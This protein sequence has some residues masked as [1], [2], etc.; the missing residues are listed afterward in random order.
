MGKHLV[1]GSSISSSFANLA[2]PYGVKGGWRPSVLEISGV[3]GADHTPFR[4]GGV[5]AGFPEAAW[6]P[7]AGRKGSA[8]NNAA[9]E[10]WPARKYFLIPRSGPRSDFRSAYFLPSEPA[11]PYAFCETP[12]EP[13]ETSRPSG[14]FTVEHAPRCE[15]SFARNPFTVTTSPG[16]SV[17]FRQPC[18]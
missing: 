2:A 10:K 13:A 5:A 6:L 11:A 3:K 4:S 14:S 15:P 1:S 17:S 8:T 9:A 18:R 16:F 7:H 12:P